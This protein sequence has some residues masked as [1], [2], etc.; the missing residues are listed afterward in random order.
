MMRQ[1]LIFPYAGVFFI[2]PLISACDEKPITF[3]LQKRTPQESALYAIKSSDADMRY[4]TLVE[5]A[6]SKALKTD[7]AVKAM[8][9]VAI[10]DPSPSVRALAA[11][12]LG[13]VADKRVLST[14]AEALDDSDERVR[15]EAAWG[16]TQFEIPGCGADAK[17]IVSA[18][19]GLLGVLSGDSAV[20][21]RINSARALGQFKNKEVVLSLIAALKDTDFAVRYEAEHSLVRLTGVTFMGQ[22][23][24]WLAWLDQTKDPFAGAGQIPPELVQPKPTFLQKSK[25][26]MY[27][28]YVDWQGPA[29]R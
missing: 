13:R 4:K 7:W 20:D 2:L 12:N 23:R 17:V 8:K 26:D 24:K 18:Q 3:D 14:L 28:F 22:A 19:K 27:R 11:H 21:T 6:K 1:K 15:Q 29:K 5:L 16:L 9:V 10:T 25:D